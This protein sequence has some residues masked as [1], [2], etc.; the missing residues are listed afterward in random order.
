MHGF[1]STYLHF[2]Y[3][4][5]HHLLLTASTQCATLQQE[6]DEPS[7]TVSSDDEASSSNSSSSD[8]ENARAAAELARRIAAEVA[9]RRNFAII[10]HPDAGKTTMVGGASRVWLLLLIETLLRSAI[11]YNALWA[12]SHCEA[13]DKVNRCAPGADCLSCCGNSSGSIEADTQPQGTY[14][15]W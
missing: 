2:C 10:S 7:A 13:S 6:Q 14:V 8:G 5:Q 12:N 15:R 9:R 11:C 4:Q 3:Q 1:S